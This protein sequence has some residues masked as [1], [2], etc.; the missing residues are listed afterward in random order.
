[1]TC[2]EILRICGNAARCVGKGALIATPLRFLT[3]L[4]PGCSMLFFWN[5]LKPKKW[6]GCLVGDVCVCV[7]LLF[8]PIFRFHVLV[9]G[10]RNRA[11]ALWGNILR[12]CQ[13]PRDRNSIQN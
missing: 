3:T 1:M 9:L 4:D 5:L 11:V 10:V 7:F 13:V 12:G 6:R 8:P 2:S